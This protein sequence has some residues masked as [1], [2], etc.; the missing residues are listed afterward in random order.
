VTSFLK[1][2]IKQTIER[3]NTAASSY[4]R[5]KEKNGEAIMRHPWWKYQQMIMLS[6]VKGTKAVSHLNCGT[7]DR[8][9][10]SASCIFYEWLLPVQWHVH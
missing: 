5:R 9:Q 8:H 4:V 2:C 6:M 7:P 10:V 3:V 1:P